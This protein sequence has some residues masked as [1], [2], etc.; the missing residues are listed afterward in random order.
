ML[1]SSKSAVQ[2]CAWFSVTVL[3]EEDSVSGLS[4][5]H[6]VLECAASE[7]LQSLAQ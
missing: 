5:A 1:S 2:V 7:L 3:V 4:C 6:S